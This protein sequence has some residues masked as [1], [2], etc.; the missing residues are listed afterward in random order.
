MKITRPNPIKALLTVAKYGR[1][2]TTKDVET[3][4]N[5][6]TKFI[7]LDTDDTI[8]TAGKNVVFKNTIA[9]TAN[10]ETIFK[11]I[12]E[13]KPYYARLSNDGLVLDDTVLE[14]YKASARP[15]LICKDLDTEETRL[16]KLTEDG[17]R[18]FQVNSDTLHESVLA[19]TNNKSNY[20]I[21]KVVIRDTNLEYSDTL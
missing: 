6:G 5:L 18:L 3:E 10:K 12:D 1:V 2:L 14:G 15:S 19:R 17:I 21:T 13:N 16:V 4:D 7:Y 8:I 9:P 20:K 11:N